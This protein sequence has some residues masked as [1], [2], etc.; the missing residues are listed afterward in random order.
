MTDNDLINELPFFHG[1]EIISKRND[2]SAYQFVTTHGTTRGILGGNLKP[3]K[4]FVWKNSFEYK[5]KKT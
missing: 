2:S 4:V 3:S 1:G 5:G